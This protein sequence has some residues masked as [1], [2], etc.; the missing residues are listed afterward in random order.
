MF[1][2]KESKLDKGIQQEI[3]AHLRKAEHRLKVAGLLQKEKEYEDAVSRAYYSVYHA[4]QAALLTE[5]LR[6]ETHRGLATLFGLHLVQTGKLPKKLAKYLR[7]L[8]DDREEG[9]YEVCLSVD[10]ETSQTAIREAEEFVKEIQNFLIPFL[11]GK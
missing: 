6:A 7:N 2:P 11:E 4:A 10:V 1:F 5:G 9:D 3:L 8:R